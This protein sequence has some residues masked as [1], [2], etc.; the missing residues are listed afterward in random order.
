[1]RLKLETNTSISFI[2][3]QFKF[4]VKSHV[5]ETTE[6]TERRQED[7]KA[8]RREDKGT[9]GPRRQRERLDEGKSFLG[10]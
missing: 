8:E 7:R 4:V 6:G 1:L 5:K 9:R 2:L 3:P 10:E